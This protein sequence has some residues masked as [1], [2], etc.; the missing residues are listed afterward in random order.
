MRLIHF[1]SPGSA[2]KVSPF[3]SITRPRHVGAT[4]ELDDFNITTG[5]VVRVV[6]QVYHQLTYFSYQKAKPFMAPSQSFDFMPP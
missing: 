4:M 6:K 1:P 3:C 5:E 2:T